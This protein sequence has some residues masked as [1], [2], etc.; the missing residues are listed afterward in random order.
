[1]GQLTRE[2]IIEELMLLLAEGLYGD[3]EEAYGYALSRDAER[4]R[5]TLNSYTT[6]LLIT[7]HHSATTSNAKEKNHIYMFASENKN[8]A[9]VRT[10]LTLAEDYEHLFHRHYHLVCQKAT[11][12]NSLSL[13]PTL[14]EQ[15][16]PSYYMQAVALTGVVTAVQVRLGD[17]ESQ[18]EHDNAR[19]LSYS[20]DPDDET[21]IDHLV[22]IANDDLVELVL[23][24][25]GDWERIADIM[26]ERYTDDVALIR[27]VL[28]SREAL[29]L[30]KGM[31]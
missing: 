8:E 23:E 30:T 28:D 5:D 19:L 4:N 27:S 13:Y 15:N 7:L 29:P 18:Y 12:V 31:L 26:V 3:P 9:W 17:T 25:P 1:M 11:A 20:P 14:K 24:R 10:Y 16:A 22:R 21:G 6:D 2:D